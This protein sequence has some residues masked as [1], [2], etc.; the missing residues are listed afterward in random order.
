MLLF[1][2]QVYRRFVSG[3]PVAHVVLSGDAIGPVFPDQEPVR[4]ETM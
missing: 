2:F 1:A 3:S 4:L